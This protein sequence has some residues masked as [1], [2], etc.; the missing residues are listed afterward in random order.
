LTR[1]FFAACFSS[2]DFQLAGGSALPARSAASRNASTS[3][4]V[5]A[6]SLKYRSSDLLLL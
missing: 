2:G 4:P 3:L 6:M 5:V 1:A